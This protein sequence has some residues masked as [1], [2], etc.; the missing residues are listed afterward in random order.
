MEVKTKFN[1]GD[2]LQHK[3]YEIIGK[4]VTIRLSERPNGT[5]IEYALFASKEYF[6][7]DK[8]IRL[9]PEKVEE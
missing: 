1:I 7:E 5:L 9:V 4:V 3:Q 6:A 8:F 2:V